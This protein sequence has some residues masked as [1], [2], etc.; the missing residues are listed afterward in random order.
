MY[1]IFKQEACQDVNKH[2]FAFYS[3]VRRHTY[4]LMSGTNSYN[5]VVPR[6]ALI[7]SWSFL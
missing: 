7:Q 1:V 5:H 2:Y 6:E 4:K 3:L